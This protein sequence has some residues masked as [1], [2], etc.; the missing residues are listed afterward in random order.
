MVFENLCFFAIDQSKGINCKD[1]PIPV[2]SSC[3]V[4]VL[5][6]AAL[7]LIVVGREPWVPCTR[8][9]RQHL[10]PCKALRSCGQ[11]LLLPSCSGYGSLCYLDFVVCSV[12]FAVSFLPCLI[13][14]FF[15]CAD[16]GGGINSQTHNGYVRDCTSL[17]PDVVPES[18]PRAAMLPKVAL[19]PIICRR[20]SAM[21]C[22]DAGSAAARP[23]QQQRGF[24][25]G[26]VLQRGRRHL[27]CRQW[28]RGSQG[29]MPA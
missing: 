3:K 13:Y 8:S 7:S 14:A 19:H 15:V 26:W 2:R 27:R 12:A 5:W 29:F 1:L 9:L 10:T 20:S 11:M 23:P 16:E 24:P 25:P 21:S 28:E 18:G 4:C 17:G 6:P 22:I